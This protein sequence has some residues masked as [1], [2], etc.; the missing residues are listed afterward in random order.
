MDILCI[1][2]GILIVTIS[3]GIG[4]YMDFKMRITTPNLYWYL[5]LIGGVFASLFISHGLKGLLS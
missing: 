4:M 5:G 2:I 1:L 3:G